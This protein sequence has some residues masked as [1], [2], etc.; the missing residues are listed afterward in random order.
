MTNVLLRTEKSK[1]P[2]WG[3]GGNLFE[4]RS[5]VDLAYFKDE[6]IL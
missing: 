4:F 3:G 1:K 5:L 6:L 2:G